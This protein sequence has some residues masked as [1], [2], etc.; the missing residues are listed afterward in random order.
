MIPDT[1]LTPADWGIRPVLFTIGAS[2]VSSYAAFVT[3]GLVAAVALYY[4]NTRGRSVGSNGLYIAV[5]AAIGGILGAKLPIWIVN[6]RE[7]LTNPGSASLLL[8]GRTIVGGILGG[9][10]AVYLTKRK[11]GITAR[12]G[13]YLVPS[14]CIGIFFGR[15]G[16]YLA[17]CCYGTPTTLP[18]GVD[19]GDAIARNP[20]QLYEAIF[21]LMLFAYAQLTFDRHPP[22]ALF[23]RFMIAYF[24]W[25][26]LIEFI[27]VNP[28]WI[29]GL[30]YY[31]VVALGVVLVYVI[32][33]AVGSREGAPR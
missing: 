21:V 1:H 16:C 30:S 13:N 5:A 14:L 28:T 27:R 25:R 29:W 33:A 10:A 24:T 7:I 18:W 22:G 26:F 8:S 31:Q 20:T 11:L 15:I 23:K 19:F 4:V 6:A 2:S 12:L 17:G 3:L 32:R 9:Y